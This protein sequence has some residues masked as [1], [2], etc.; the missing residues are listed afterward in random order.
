MKK[1]TMFLAALLFVFAVVPAG[2]V[3]AAE[4][5][6]TQDTEF[7]NMKDLISDYGK[8]NQLGA[9]SGEYKGEAVTNL[10]QVKQTDNSVTITWNP[11]TGADKYVIY[12][13]NVDKY[14]NMYLGNKIA[15]T[16]N[17]SHTLFINGMT[18]IGVVPYGAD[19]SWNTDFCDI[20]FVAPV[21]KQVT[22]LKYNGVF[23]KNNKLN[24]VWDE[25]NCVGFE[26]YLYNRK[27]KLSQ[28][29]DET[30]YR[31]TTFSKTNTQNIYSVKVKPYVLINDG[32]QKLYGP[33]SKTLYAVPQPKITSKNSDVKLHSVKLKWKKVNG[34]TKYVVYASSKATKGYKKVAT[35]KKSK[36]S[37]TV[38]KFKGK[39]IDT[40]S[41]KYFKIVTYAKFGK[42]TV[43]SQ[44]KYYLSAKTTVYYR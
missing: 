43:K 4:V 18:L 26:A 27:G 2:K 19:G 39:T 35:V 8:M 24:V 1:I 3:K 17:T 13:V 32:T 23:A 5:S 42:K 9:A 7:T 30:R 29:V 25:N 33:V 38:K 21:P 12:Q 11:A 22:G 31:S 14:E 36:S 37:Y 28:T 20:I 41:K 16:K 10:K 44:N 15:E 40:R 6:R 34:A